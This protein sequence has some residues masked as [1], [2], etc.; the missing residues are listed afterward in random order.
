MTLQAAG[1]DRSVE[2]QRTVGISRTVNPLPG[3]DPVRYRQF[4]KFI[5]LSIEIGLGFAAGADYH[6]KALLDRDRLG[7]LDLIDRRLKIA[8]VLG[9]HLEMQR[10]IGGMQNVGTGSEVPRNGLPVGR[11]RSKMMRG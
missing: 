8:L 2:T 9:S 7:G 11:P 6:D 4:E 10:G 5:A 3:F 1:N